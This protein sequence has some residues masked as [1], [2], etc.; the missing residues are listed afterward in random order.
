VDETVA[1][2]GSTRQM[3]GSAIKDADLRVKILEEVK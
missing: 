3:L 1:S 2:G